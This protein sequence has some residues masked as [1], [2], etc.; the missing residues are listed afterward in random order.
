M[1]GCEYGVGPLD[2]L[3]LSSLELEI[4]MSAWWTAYG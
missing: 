2:G 1:T 4:L 3:C